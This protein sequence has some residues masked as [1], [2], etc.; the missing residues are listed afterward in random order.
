MR[1]RNTENFYYLFYLF[2]FESIVQ[3]RRMLNDDDWMWLARLSRRT[4]RASLDPVSPSPWRYPVSGGIRRYPVV[5][6]GIQWY[7]VSRVCLSA[8]LNASAAQQDRRLPVLYIV[9]IAIA[10]TIFFSK[11]MLF[12]A[13]ECEF[14]TM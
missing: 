7:P 8:G 5:S 10:Q 9:A 12:L 4:L 13:D 3:L 2:F 6:S 1:I 14:V 11:R